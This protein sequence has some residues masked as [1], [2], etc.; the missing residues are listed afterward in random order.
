MR[1]NPRI[2]VVHEDAATAARLATEITAVGC[3]VITTTNFEDGKKLLAGP[4]PVLL[5]AGIR[6]G[7]FNGLH[8]VIR[9][10][11]DHPAMSAIVIGEE[12]N[13]TFEAEVA[14][15]GAVFMVGA[16]ASP[17]LLALVAAA[18][19]KYGVEA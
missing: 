7:E 5:I 6:L 3:T 16:Q 19:A 13:P 4:P 12:P 8:L 2:L 10:L 15:H 9:G 1:Q 11:L 18:L 17:E 14:S